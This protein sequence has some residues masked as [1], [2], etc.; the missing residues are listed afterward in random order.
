[1]IFFGYGVASNRFFNELGC[2]DVFLYIGTK[3]QCGTC[4]MKWG[5]SITEMDDST[6]LCH[7]PTALRQSN[8]FLFEE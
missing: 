4:T 3:I 6:N 2:V 1:M 8:T 7:K 5:T